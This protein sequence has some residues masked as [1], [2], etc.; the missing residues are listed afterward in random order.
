[1][2]GIA[3]LASGFSQIHCGLSIYH[4]QTVV[5]LTWF[6]SSTHLTTMT[7]LRRYTHDNYRFRIVRLGLMLLLVIMLAVALLPTGGNCGLNPQELPNCGSVHNDFP[8]GKSSWNKIYIY[9]PGFPV[10]CCFGLLGKKPI[11]SSNSDI[12]LS[13]IASQVVLFFSSLTRCIK[14]FRGS[15]KFAKEWLRKKPSRVWRKKLTNYQSR[16]TER[17]GTQHRYIYIMGTAVLILIRAAFDLA[18]SLVWEVS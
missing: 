12:L 1:V 2:T 6:S 10:R 4:W 13:M 8:K 9:F 11:F 7:F 17:A 16:S 15:S 14:V 3:I 18:E 5:Y